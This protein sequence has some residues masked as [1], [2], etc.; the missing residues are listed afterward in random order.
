MN[1]ISTSAPQLISISLVLLA[2]GLSV[3]AV[4]RANRQRLALRL[5]AGWAAAAGLWGLAY[6]PARAVPVSRQEAIVLT[7]DYQADTLQLLLRQP[8]AGTPLWRYGARPTADTPALHSLLALRERTPALRRVHVLGRGLPPAALA[9]AGPL[10]LVLHRDAPAFA[11]FAAAQWSRQLT[12]G[13]TLEVQGRLAAPTGKAPTWVV[14]RAAGRGQDS[15][16]L[17]ADGGFR[18]RYQ[19]KATGL[20]TYELRARRGAATVA[21]EPVPVEVGAAPPLRVL[22]LASAPGFEFRFL[23]DH[24]AARQHAV[25]LRVQVSRGLTQTDFLNQPAHDLRRLTPALLARYDALI[26][27]DGTLTALRGA[28]V[29]ALRAAIERTG[30]GLILLADPAAL[31]R[32][33]PGRAAFAVRPGPAADLRPQPLRWPEG[34]PHAVALLPASLRLRGAEALATDARRRPVVG[35]V[36]AGAGRVAVSAVAATFSW[37]LQRPQAETYDAFWSRLLTAV[38]RP[39]PPAA[40]WQVLTPWPRPHAPVAL[41][42]ETTRLPAAPPTVAAAGRP[43]VPLALRQDTRLPEWSTARFWPAAA[44]WHRAQLPGQPDHW[45][46]VF[47]ADAWPGPEA[48]Q[49]QQAAARLAARP[50]SIGPAKPLTAAEPW[51]AGWFLALFLVGAGGLWLEE[52]W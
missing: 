26:V 3:A 35:V 1:L 4:R 49:R 11:G 5:V 36:R 45:F 51:P 9:E 32:A 30:L 27:D 31:P 14:L 12:L 47:A 10:P 42:L 13:Q 33:L 28:E 44:G 50:A 18:L 17:A 24:L 46:Y 25:A 20:T 48:A 37:L 43:A 7:A 38:A 15:V 8:G 39:V 21:R 6:P 29:R 41:R 34:P 52:K 2:V 40:R 19:P 16:K 22:L 23:K